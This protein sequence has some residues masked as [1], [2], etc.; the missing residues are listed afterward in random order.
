M[1][2][3]TQTQLL[4]ELI[5]LLKPINNLSRYYIQQINAQIAANAPAEEATADEAVV[6]G[7]D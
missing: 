5:E 6:K 2:K 3:K 1:A 4:Q 7:E